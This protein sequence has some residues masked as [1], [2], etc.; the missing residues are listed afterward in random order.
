MTIIKLTI[1]SFSTGRGAA[2]M[3][4][5]SLQK[6]MKISI[7]EGI[8]A[9]IF[10]SIAT[11]GSIFITKMAQ[12]LGATPLHFSVLSAIGRF[13]E[14]FQLVGIA[15]AGKQPS[16]KRPVMLLTSLGRSVAFLFGLLP[17]LVEARYALWVFIIL[18]FVSVSLQAMSNNMWLAW[19][20]DIFPNR[21]RGR[22]FANRSLYLLIAGLLTGYVI[23]LFIDLYDKHPGK[24][25]STIFTFFGSRGFFTP[26]NNLYCFFIIFFIAAVVGLLGLF[27]LRK[28]DERNRTVSEDSF[29]EQFKTAFADK[30]FRNLLIY[31]AWWMLAV[32]VGAPYWQP[33]MLQTLKI[34]VLT[35]QMYGTVSVLGSVL[36]LRYWGKFIDRFGNKSAMHVA[37]VMGSINPLIWVFITP[38]SYWPIFIEAF[39]SGIMWAGANVIAMNF[40]LAVAPPEKKQMYSAI[41]GVVSSL[42]IMLTMLLSGFI[43]P[44]PIR[45]GSLS[46]TSYQVLF[47]IT[48]I[49]R[50]TTHIPLARVKEP[51]RKP[52]KAALSFLFDAVVR[53]VRLLNQ[54]K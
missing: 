30:N 6:N 53:R 45:I 2:F 39:T 29:I 35:I 23:A 49:L 48:G 14:I 37:V 26:E 21:I 15:I 33:F 51:G 43:M 40:V 41:F 46:L 13:S 5:L 4:R 19:I 47:A 52:F 12:I 22:F 34:S 25:A 28:Q 18:F 27:V 8:F 1:Q 10:S 7:T 9:Q 3:K 31:G 38:D 11:P 17:L 36:A 50:F 20:S 42:S 44:P 24:I 16:L 54:P 32:G